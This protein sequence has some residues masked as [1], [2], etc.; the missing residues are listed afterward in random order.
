[1]KIK[2]AKAC[3]AAL[4]AVLAVTAMSGCGGEKSSDQTAGT[5]NKYGTEY[6]LDAKGDKL[7]I[8]IINSVHNEYKSY[9][10]MPFFQE[11]QKRTGVELD[12][13]GP[14]GGQFEESFNLMIASGEL[15]DIILYDWGDKKVAGGPAKYIKEGYI[16]ELND[17]IDKY[18]PNLKKILNDNPELDKAVQTDEGQYYVF[19][20]MNLEKP[21][22]WA[23]PT[24]R[25]D[26]LDDLGLDIPETIDDWH[27]ML[28][29]F[30]DKKGSTSPLWYIDW[31]MESTGFLSGAYGTQQCY[32]LNDDGEIEYGPATQKWKSFLELLHQWYS[33]G[34]I[35]KDIAT[36]DSDTAKSK[37][38]SGKNGAYLG[39]GGD[40]GPFAEMTAKTDPKAKLVGVPY[41]TLNKGETPEFGICDLKY[42]GCMS[43]AITADCKNVELAAKFL[44][45]FYSD[46]GRMFANFGIEGV[47]YNMVDGYPKLSD[48]IINS[49]DIQNEMEKYSNSEFSV[50]DPRYYEQRLLHQEQKDAVKVWAQTNAEAHRLPLLLPTVDE[51]NEISKYTTEIETY[52][53]EMLIKYTTG[54]ESLDTFDKYLA[55]L[56]E[57]GLPRVMEIY[58]AAYK[59]YQER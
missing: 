51:S 31:M 10:D 42:S 19:P 6:P 55:H 57:L 49:G 4:A 5:E 25:K 12:I 13:Q 32:Y 15:P 18:A 43:S 2:F 7:S 48:E 29:E 3:A 36:L 45:Y 14:T 53:N 28:T 21:A 17:V 50:V 47:S 20:Y 33:E 26:W 59:R 30:K 44:D 24:V 27:T 40:L 41:P 58:N 38:I 54:A 22:A 52:V 9:Q 8:W 46:E 34:L 23:G 16:I 39:S 37:V 11:A 35:D 56:D 1:M